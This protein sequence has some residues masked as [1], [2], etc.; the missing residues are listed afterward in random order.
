MT[1][2]VNSPIHPTTEFN[3]SG[4]ELLAKRQKG[5]IKCRVCGKRMKR[6][7]SNKVVWASDGLPLLFHEYTGYN[8]IDVHLKCA[9]KEQTK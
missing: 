4:R 7:P 9:E 5:M 2:K 1:D 8:L 6:F 3:L